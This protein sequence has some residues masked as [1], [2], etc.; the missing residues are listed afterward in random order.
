MADVVSLSDDTTIVT[1]IGNYLDKKWLERLEANLCYD[2]FGEQRPLPKSRGGTVVWHA[3]LN[4]GKGHALGEGSVPAAS[5]IS[6]RK[7][8]ATPS[9][10]YDLHGYSDI[11][12]IESE[13]PILGE[14]VANLGYGAALDRD[15]MIGDQIG[16]GSAAS[17]GVAD[18]ASVALM[19][20]HS[21]GFGMMDG[22]TGTMYWSAA[23]LLN[24]RFSTIA[25]IAQIRKV[26][27]QLKKFNAMTFSDGLLR[28]IIH[29]TVSDHIRQDTNF[30]TW[31]AYTQPDAMRKG[32]LG[33]IEGVLFEE[34]TE[35]FRSP[36][37]S[38]TWSGYVSGGASV[39]GTLI[40]GRGAYGVTKVE[41]GD[42][43]G[44]VV[45]LAKA[46]K[47]DPLN[48]KTLVGYKYMIAAKVL[49]PS[50]GIILTWL[51]G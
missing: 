4:I 18:A 43:K 35:A 13:L 20:I 24:G 29:P 32:K 12:D 34:S 9:Q 28:G 39:Y 15:Y 33:V 27:T 2:K 31:L 3:M 40:F 5:A 48:Q 47:A 16:F 23:A 10:R 8:S 46:D 41:G 36:T 21:Q 38:S 44:E 6:T 26:V 49:N 51:E 25:T 14:L 1:M 42:Q 11:V 7:V 22:N 17:T 45:V 37:L 19:S 50:C 30:A